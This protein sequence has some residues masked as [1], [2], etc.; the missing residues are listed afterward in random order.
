MELDIHAVPRPERPLHAPARVPRAGIV[1]YWS[2]YSTR[3]VILFF[4][5]YLLIKQWGGDH[6]PGR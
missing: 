3:Q 5:I 6:Q 2:M 4:F 1:L